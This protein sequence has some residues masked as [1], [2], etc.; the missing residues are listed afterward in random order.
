MLR[1]GGVSN[2]GMHLRVLSRAHLCLFR[3]ESVDSAPIAY[4]HFRSDV[5][6]RTMCLGLFVV[7]AVISYRC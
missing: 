7:R 4:Q 3:I 1:W 2:H 6:N 5:A